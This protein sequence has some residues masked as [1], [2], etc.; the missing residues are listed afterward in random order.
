MS[1]LEK[2]RTIVTLRSDGY[3]VIIDG[4]L[5][6]TPQNNIIILPT[7]RLADAIAKEWD[8]FLFER[9]AREQKY[10]LHQQLSKETKPLIKK[11]IKVDSIKVMNHVDQSF[12]IG[13]VETYS[14]E[15]LPPLTQLAAL[16]IDWSQKKDPFILEHLYKNGLTDPC[17]DPNYSP[18]SFIPSEKWASLQKWH[19]EAYLSSL[20]KSLEALSWWH[21]VVLYKLSQVT[22]SLLI[23]LCLLHEKL[24]PSQAFTLTEM[25][26]WLKNCPLTKGM[27]IGQKRLFLRTQLIV[28]SR[29]LSFLK[30]ENSP[31]SLGNQEG[32][33][34]PPHQIIQQK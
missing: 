15:T 19:T 24:N 13:K 20:E 26:S 9:E 34:L 21:L 33:T 4:V 7:N 23:S 11:E 17:M 25:I 8:I 14:Y 30:E 10:K 5:L 28:C 6:T 12:A 2:K 1:P 29:F 3:E 22:G 16:S 31:N 18:P 27:T 32:D